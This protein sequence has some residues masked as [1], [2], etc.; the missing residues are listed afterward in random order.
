[1]YLLLK[2]IYIDAKITGFWAP[3]LAFLGLA[4]ANLTLVTFSLYEIGL[5]MVLVANKF[6]T[7]KIIT[8]NEIHD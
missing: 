2:K 1:M 5:I 8:V 7:Q 3:Y 4:L 6:Y